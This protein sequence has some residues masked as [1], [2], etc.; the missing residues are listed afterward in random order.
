[1]KR[2]LLV[3]AVITVLSL[4]VMA[5]GSPAIDDGQARKLINSQGCKAC[6]ALEAH[7][8]T[9]APSFEAMRATLSRTEI[10]LQLINPEHRHGK[11]RIAD[12]SNLTAAEVDALVVF[13]KP[14]P[15]L[16]GTSN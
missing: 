1:M 12:F 13:I 15:S 5:F 4:S 11:G 9:A 8:G 14:E 6:H 16:G 3:T 7:G 2:T 10:R